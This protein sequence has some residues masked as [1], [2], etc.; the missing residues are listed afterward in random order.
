MG[1]TGEG[2]MGSGGKLISHPQLR[3]EFLKK[4]NWIGIIIIKESF[5]KWIRDDQSGSVKPET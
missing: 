5:D 2:M 3:S 4:T 1:R